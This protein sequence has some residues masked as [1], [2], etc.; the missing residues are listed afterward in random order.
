VNPDRK[1]EVYPGEW[2]PECFGHT[3]YGDGFKYPGTCDVRVCSSGGYCYA[4]LR[5]EVEDR[6]PEAAAE[7]EARRKVLREEG[8]DSMSIVRTLAAQGFPPTTQDA[9][10][11]N[12][13]QGQLASGLWWTCFDNDCDTLI[14]KSETYCHRHKPEE[15]DDG[16]GTEGSRDSGPDT[17]TRDADGPALQ[18]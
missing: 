10:L 4:K 15:D 12:T 6:D 1:V 3:G 11:E 18:P 16:L 13:R 2:R 8:L 17:G 14:R 9:V 5:A 7:Y